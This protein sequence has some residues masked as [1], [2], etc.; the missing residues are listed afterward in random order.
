M[1]YRLT[2]SSLVSGVSKQVDA[3]VHSASLAFEIEAAVLRSTIDGVNVDRSPAVN[4]TTKPIFRSEKYRITLYDGLAVFFDKVVNA[5]ASRVG[6]ATNEGDVLREPAL[7]FSSSRK[8]AHRLLRAF[9][10]GRLDEVSGFEAL[11]L[12]DD[13]G[14]SAVLLVE[15][16]IRFVLAHEFG[17][18]LSRMELLPLRDTMS[19]VREAAE[20]LWSHARTRIS[21]IAFSEKWTNEIAADVIGLRTHLSSYQTESER[22]WALA[23]VEMFM[24]VASYLERDADVA[25]IIQVSSHP[26]AGARL[27]VIRHVTSSNDT[28]VLAMGRALEQQAMQ[29]F[30]E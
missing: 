12:S 6:V 27:Q 29:L 26:P 8:I 19:W 3:L 14:R 16:V 2:E 25:G 17:H 15:S 24:I 1:R 22:T 23:G 18:I 7:S 13:Q 20:T 21:S 4:A 30:N 10:E 28:V 11:P 5:F 9:W